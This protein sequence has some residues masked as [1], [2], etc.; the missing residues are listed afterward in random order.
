VAKARDDKPAKAGYSIHFGG[1][2]GRK[3]AGLVTLAGKPRERG[4]NQMRFHI[5]ATWRAIPH[6]ARLTS[7]INIQGF[8]TPESSC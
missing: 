8:R 1:V 4:W 5:V 7:K 3:T 6:S 2:P